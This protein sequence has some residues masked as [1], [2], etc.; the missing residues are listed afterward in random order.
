MQH[1]SFPVPFTRL[2]KQGLW[3]TLCLL[4][5]PQAAPTYQACLAH[6]IIT[7]QEEKTQ[8]QLETQYVRKDLADTLR[9]QHEHESDDQGPGAIGA[10][11]LMRAQNTLAF[12]RAY[13]ECVESILFVA[14]AFLI[15]LVKPYASILGLDATSQSSLV[16]EHCSYSSF[17]V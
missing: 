8:S 14:V 3:L 17:L 11:K 12:A 4:L 6:A 2:R 1:D 16:Q 13:I 15:P 5:L 7:D 9:K 10:S